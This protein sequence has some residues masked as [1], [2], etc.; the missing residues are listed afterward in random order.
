MAERFQIKLEYDFAKQMLTV[1]FYIQRYDENNFA[2]DATV[3]A[4]L[5]E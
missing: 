4:M 3:Q 1:L 5:N 2:V